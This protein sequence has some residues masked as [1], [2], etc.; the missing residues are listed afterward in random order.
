MNVLAGWLALII[1][2]VAPLK[3]SAQAP[4]RAEAPA[5]GARSSAQQSGGDPVAVEM[6]GVPPAGKRP[7]TVLVF[8]TEDYAKLTNPNP[9]E[10]FRPEI[11]TADQGAKNLGGMFGLLP[12]KSQVAY[13]Y[14]ER[15]ESIIVAISGEA[16]EVIEGQEL[17]FKTGDIYYIPAGKKHTTI[18]RTSQEF[19]YLEFFTSPP[20]AS[21]F[22]EVK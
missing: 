19:R 12:P 8:K 6:R 7:P 22:V 13:H 1:V 10:P 14:H 3:S 20:M 11:L 9:G 16:I 21:D 4:T 17:P 18:N 5:Q 15:R 2:V